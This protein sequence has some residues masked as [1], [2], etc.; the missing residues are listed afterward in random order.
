MCG[1][2]KEG[3]RG[4]NVKKA[5]PGQAGLANETEYEVRLAGFPLGAH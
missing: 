4:W 1:I 5:E 2:Q 3:Q